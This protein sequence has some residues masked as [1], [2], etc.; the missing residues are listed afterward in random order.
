MH[1]SSAAALNRLPNIRHLQFSPPRTRQKKLYAKRRGKHKNGCGVP[2]TSE[3]MVRASCAEPKWREQQDV[4]IEGLEIGRP[5][6]WQRLI[7]GS[8]RGRLPRQAHGKRSSRGNG[9]RKRNRA[10]W[11]AATES[12]KPRPMRLSTIGPSLVTAWILW[13]LG[14]SKGC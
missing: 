7:E 9:N 1:A 2:R 6:A 4:R 13:A 8:G 14:C 12:T 11:S 10:D 5:G 3:S